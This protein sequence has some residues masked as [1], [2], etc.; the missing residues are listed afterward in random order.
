M[1]E[2][3]RLSGGQHGFRNIALYE[4][5]DL[6]EEMEIAGISNTYVNARKTFYS[7][8]GRKS[9]FSKSFFNVK[10]E[11]VMQYGVDME[12]LQMFDPPRKVDER[13]LSDM[14]L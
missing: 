10:G 13:Y 5:N 7:G 11:E 1:C 14:V 12:T 8:S 4:A 2:Y 3:I 6:M 9:L